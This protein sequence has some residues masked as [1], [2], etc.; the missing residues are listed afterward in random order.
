MA[1]LG[2]VNI[3]FLLMSVKIYEFLNHW[4]L[5]WSLF[6]TG[7][8]LMPGSGMNRGWILGGVLMMGSSGERLQQRQC[9]AV[10]C[11]RVGGQRLLQDTCKSGR[12]IFAV[13]K[14]SAESSKTPY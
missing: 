2:R 1:F 9:A 7:K 11:Q 4:Q 5:G 14:S 8:S 6:E 10:M 13:A 3:M 12:K